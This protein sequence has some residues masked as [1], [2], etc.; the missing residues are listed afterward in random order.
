[1]AKLFAV[2]RNDWYQ[3]TDNVAAFFQRFGKRFPGLLW[4]QL[5]Q[6]RQRLRSPLS[7]L[8]PGRRFAPLATALNETIERENPYLYSMLSEFGK[9]LYFPKGILAQAPRP[10]TRPSA[11]TPR[12]ASP[13]KTASPCS[14]RR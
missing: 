7:L 8:K 6:L 12:L 1:M 3:E 14:C 2:D 9:R 4:E 11:T 5:E 10:R 13:A